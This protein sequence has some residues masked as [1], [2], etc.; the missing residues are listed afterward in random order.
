V[1]LEEFAEPMPAW[2]RAERYLGGGTRT[3]SRYAADLEV[4]PRY[5]PQLGSESFP[6]PTFRV[7]HSRG[8]YLTGSLH[9]DLHDH[10]RDDESFLLP[11]HPETLAMPG[12]GAQLAGCRRGPS[13]QVVPSANARTVFVQRIGD[14]PA[15]AH[16]VK[17]HYPKRLSRFTRRLRQP[18]ITLQLWVADELAAIGAPVLPEVGGGVI[19]DDP[20]QAW[21]YLL[22]EAAV[23]QP[24]G[25]PYLVPLFALYGRDIRAPAEPTLLEQLVAASGD[26]PQQWVVR[27]LIEPMVTLWADALLRTGCAIELHG[28]NTLL[29]LSGD[30]RHTAVAYRDCAVYVDPALRS[31]RGLHR[32]LPPRNVISRD[33]PHP[34]AQVLSLVYDSFL[35]H[36]TL[37]Y[38]ARLLHQRFGVAEAALHTAARRVLA[39]QLGR[40]G[41]LPRTVYYYDDRLHADGGWRLIDTGA[42]PQWR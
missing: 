35:G 17:L 21:G 39:G 23:R 34:R 19:G 5:H 11:V 36:H 10:Y 30:L 12:I 41:L 22:R 33:V 2:Q 32:P 29:C 26:D 1:L 18:V 27:R 16:F 20:E 42:A 13:L 3:Y 38:V 28:Q 7:P 25:L 15:P 8:R 4:S 40:Q 9:S 6:V 37:A 31:A 24:A 14:Q